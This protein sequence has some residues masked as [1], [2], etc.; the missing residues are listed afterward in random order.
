[1]AWGLTHI[2]VQHEWCES[3]TP[4]NLDVVEYRG[5]ILY[6]LVAG[7]FKHC[8]FSI[9]YMGCHPSHWRTHIFQDGYCTTNQC[10]FVWKF[11]WLLSQSGMVLCGWGHPEILLDDWKIHGKSLQ[12][13]V[14]G[15]VFKTKHTLNTI[16]VGGLEHFLF[17]HILGIR[18]PTD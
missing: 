8:L 18:I 16:L 5:G 7:G 2:K 4:R 3:S 11:R 13:R 1:M 10:R 14:I 15:R 12:L 17:F 6:W 9:S